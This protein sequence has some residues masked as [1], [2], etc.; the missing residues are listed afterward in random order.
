MKSV[1]NMGNAPGITEKTNG[2]QRISAQHIL[3]AF[4]TLLSG[5]YGNLALIAIAVAGI[6]LRMRNLGSVVIAYG[7]EP[8]IFSDKAFLESN[9]AL[10]HW[11]VFWA[12]S[13]F[14]QS[15]FVCRLPSVLF[16]IGSG[17]LIFFT[18]K[19]LAGSK[20]GLFSLFFWAINGH[21]YAFEK[22]CRFYATG[23]FFIL[24]SAFL[25]MVLLRSFE[26]KFSITAIFF[27]L[28]LYIVSAVLAVCSMML[29]VL[30][31]AGQLLFVAFKV[32]NWLLKLLIIVTCSMPVICIF[33]LL[34]R[35]DANALSRINYAD[36]SFKSLFNIPAYLGGISCEIYLNNTFFTWIFALVL[37]FSII[38]YLTLYRKNK[39]ALLLPLF[40]VFLP[41][42]AIIVYSFFYK[43]IYQ[44]DNLYL[45]ISF[46]MII[47]G[48]AISKASRGWR[49]GILAIIAVFSGYLIQ[50]DITL[51]CRE[52]CMMYK[53]IREGGRAGDILIENLGYRRRISR[54]TG[55][56]SE[57][58]E[59]DM[60]SVLWLNS[61]VLRAFP[62]YINSLASRSRLI[63]IDDLAGTEQLLNQILSNNTWKSRVYL[64]ETK[65]KHDH[66]NSKNSRIR[67]YMVVINRNI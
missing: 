58:G 23:E 21:L 35:Y 11:L 33:Q 7:E 54:M 16:G 46:V 49:I 13:F 66:D 37:L 67:F 65:S 43:N 63:W 25:L 4:N 36:I 64:I 52:R 44:S 1:V 9:G 34:Y 14:G 15:A 20:A 31:I 5:D 62:N 28:L 26:K 55:L 2:S 59:N 50:P 24:L 56:P 38:Y 30:V 18:G 6:Y 41:V 47:F 45:Q 27:F 19:M 51:D 48:I 8:V 40:C 57:A 22:Y 17:V 42:L 60:K 32:R 29:S 61:N 12:K 53:M 10:H 39:S 3:R